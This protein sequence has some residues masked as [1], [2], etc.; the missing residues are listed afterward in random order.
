LGLA[1]ALLAGQPFAADPAA[2][3]VRLQLIP[4][5]T[6]PP[7][8]ETVDATFTVPLR[9]AP[10]FDCIAVASPT[11][12]GLIAVS[13][14]LLNRIAALKDST[15]RIKGLNMPS[16]LLKLRA[17]GILRGANGATGSHGCTTLAKPLLPDSVYLLG[18]LL[19]S[20]Q[21]AVLLDDP[22]GWLPAIRVH[23][24]ATAGV[25]GFV[26]Y[27]VPDASGQSAATG[28][29]GTVLNNRWWGR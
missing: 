7:P 18:T 13:R 12:N 16:S 14:D 24:S 6:A 11:G 27:E 21:A 8:G 26:S 9:N 29:F 2:P 1:A 25:G 5:F 19:E 20:G 28:M 17:L 4:A 3:D 15:D 22:A 23:Y 10:T